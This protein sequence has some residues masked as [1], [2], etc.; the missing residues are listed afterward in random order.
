VP[1]AATETD[2]TPEVLPT[3]TVAR[4]A[5]ALAILDPALVAENLTVSAVPVMSAAETVA[6][7]PAAEFVSAGVFDTPNV[8]DK[9]ALVM[10]MLP[11]VK[12]LFN[13]TLVTPVD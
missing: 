4:L 2:S 8:A 6:K 10:E 13:V 7:M 1:V 5:A 11:P 12:L 3:F 9:G